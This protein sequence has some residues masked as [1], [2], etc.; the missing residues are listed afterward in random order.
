MT[1]FISRGI[2]ASIIFF[3]MIGLSG[4]LEP[5]KV[6][7][8][9]Q[10]ARPGIKY[11]ARI[12][13]GGSGEYTITQGE[14][15]DGLA[16]SSDGTITGQVDSPVSFSLTIADTNP[17]LENII[18]S[19]DLGM[20]S[21]QTNTD[22]Y[23]WTVLVHFAIDNNIS[24]YMD[25][26]M[27]I[28]AN[29]LET[30]EGIKAS[31]LNNDI[32]IFVMM[33][34]DKTDRY[35]EGY[36]MLTGGAFADDIVA[37]T[38]EINSGAMSFTKD[39]MDYALGNTGYGSEKFMYSVFNH[40]SGFADSDNIYGNKYGTPDGLP[41]VDRVSGGMSTLG[42]GFD[43]NSE[44]DCLT[45]YE[46]GELNKYLGEQIGHKVDLFYPYA[47]LM[48]GVEL[49]YEIRD[50]ADYILFSEEAFPA[51]FW[52]YE[53]LEEIIENPD[54]TGLDLGKA[55]CDSAHGYFKRIILSRDFTLSVL[56]LSKMNNLYA[57]INTYSNAA[58]TDIEDNDTNAFYNQAADNSFSMLEGIKNGN[59]T[60]SNY[61]YLDLG[62]YMDHICASGTI[63]ETVKAEANTVKNAMAN[64]LA[65]KTSFGHENAS[66]MTI[67]HNIQGSDYT[68][69]T[70]LYGELFAFGDNA[71]TG[72]MEALEP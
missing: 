30:L 16:F 65:Y 49:A 31:D 52:S 63:A 33:D 39:F 24:Y 34:A 40:G 58:K 59:D 61:Y 47:C 21:I 4:C 67:F 17:V 44:D 28:V 5:V 37:A 57:A 19:T 46:L 25:E 72:Y 22:Q 2:K 36:Y 42:I 43:E 48:G 27:G 69:S 23:K 51:D 56:D 11:H 14:V 54:A 70:V 35:E 1:M 55:F 50:Y 26:K 64:S 32:C 66:G 10:K 3:L 12:V 71:W 45:H 6:I 9:P 8:S 41:P 18:P 53:A 7:E 15:P 13:Q 60:I 20:V 68:Y 29:Y 38:S 62:D